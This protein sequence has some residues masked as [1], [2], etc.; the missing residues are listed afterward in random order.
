MI[1]ISF[2]SALSLSLIGCAPLQQAPLVYSSKQVFG[3]D[4]STPT[5]E[6]PGIT[7]NVGYKGVDAAYIPVA[8][9]K[10]ADRENADPE[11]K[12]ISA[13]YG[14]GD[15]ASKENEIEQAA[16]IEQLE[17]ALNRKESA[18]TNL[19]NINSITTLALSYNGLIRSLVAADAATQATI[20]TSIDDATKTIQGDFPGFYSSNSADFS[21]K[22]F[23]N[24]K[25][26]D[27]LDKNKSKFEKEYAAA[28]SDV[29]TARDELAKV[30]YINQTDAMSVYG[31]FESNTSLFQPRDT[32][33]NLG[34]MF[35]TGVAAQNLT[36]GIQAKGFLEQ[37][38]KAVELITDVTKKEDA[39]V[40][41]LNKLK[42]L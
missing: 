17:G 23:I 14:E 7:F 29:R 11:I 4:I 42:S 19:K 32:S 39:A 16:K 1:K 22:S 26:T 35:S 15:K 38:L 41:C 2:A 34:K 40:N 8:V 13:N 20:N 36:K 6:S 31:S 33:N 18:G 25:Q 27:E 12:I 3:A 30:L 21:S 37:C 10:E 28:E 5:S 24:K 9:S